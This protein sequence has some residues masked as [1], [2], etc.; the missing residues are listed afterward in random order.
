M[1]HRDTYNKVVLSPHA[2]SDAHNAVN[3]THVHVYDV[4]TLHPAM[5]C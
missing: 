2:L 1:P 3:Y 4:Q 5:H